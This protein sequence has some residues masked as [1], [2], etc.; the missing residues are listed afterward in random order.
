MNST[1]LI[2]DSNFFL[3]LTNVLKTVLKNSA[4]VKQNE[5]GDSYE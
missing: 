3:K 1:Q 2:V 4:R 5:Y